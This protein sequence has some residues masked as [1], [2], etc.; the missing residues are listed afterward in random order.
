[1]IDLT[2]PQDFALLALK[3]FSPERPGHVIQ[4][5]TLE[6]LVRKGLAVRNGDGSFSITPRGMAVNDMT[7]PEGWESS[8][9]H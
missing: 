5:S 6:A 3:H 9:R 1:M 8:Q 4:A 7:P 2:E